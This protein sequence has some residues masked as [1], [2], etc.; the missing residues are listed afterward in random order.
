MGMLQFKTVD[1]DIIVQMDTESSIEVSKSNTISNSSVMSGA[2]TSDNMQEG[3]VTVSVQGRVTYSKTASQQDNPNPSEWIDLI[4]NAI[5]NK[6]VFK[7]DYDKHESGKAILKS[8]DNMVI[9]DYGYTV[10]RFED[11]I[12]TRITFNEIYITDAAIVTEL[13]PLP[14]KEDKPQL[15]DAESNEGVGTEVSD[16]VRRSLFAFLDDLLT[17]ED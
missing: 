9:S 8:Y 17:G 6:R 10:D 16:K 15:Q 4:D 14:K 1:S 5:R 11:T 7:L 13:D 3:N 12:T 2:N